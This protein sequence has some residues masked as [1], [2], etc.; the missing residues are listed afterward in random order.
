MPSTSQLRKYARQGQGSLARLQS[1]LSER[2]LALTDNGDEVIQFFYETMKDK[3]VKIRAR[4][5]AATWLADRMWGKEPEVVH[6]NTQGIFETVLQASDEELLAMTRG[7]FESNLP[8][9]P[10]DDDHDSEDEVVDTSARV[11]GA[12]SSDSAASA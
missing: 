6:L 4:L 10:Q 7:V 2:I 3:K 12:G 5:A 8:P 11:E 9:I 1:E